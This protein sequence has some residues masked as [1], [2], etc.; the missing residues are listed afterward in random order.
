M[1]DYHEDE[2][3]LQPQLTGWNKFWDEAMF[4]GAEINTINRY[5]QQMRDYYIEHYNG[6]FDATIDPPGGGVI[7]TCRKCGKTFAVNRGE[8]PALKSPDGK[9]T[10]DVNLCENCTTGVAKRRGQYQFMPWN[11]DRVKPKISLG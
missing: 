6:P 9:T 7:G 11:P 8:L 5:N 1:E 2:Y 3:V 10:L 4:G